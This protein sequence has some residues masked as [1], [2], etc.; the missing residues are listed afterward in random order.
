MKIGDCGV[1]EIFI[2]PSQSEMI[3]VASKKTNRI[4]FTAD[5]RSPH[6]VW[7]WDASKAIHYEMLPLLGSHRWFALLLCGYRWFCWCFITFK[8]EYLGCHSSSSPSSLKDLRLVSSVLTLGV[9]K[10]ADLGQVDLWGFPRCSCFL[11]AVV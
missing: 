4:R 1:F 6:K 5:T 11:S 8:L 7:V 10:Y 3:K 2:N 9:S